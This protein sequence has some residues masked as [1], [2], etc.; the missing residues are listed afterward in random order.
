MGLI[1]TIVLKTT[2]D[3]NLR[4][5]YC[6]EFKRDEYEDLN[7][8]S[9]SIEFL[10]G[11]IE[12]FAILFPDSEILWMLHGGEPLLKGKKFFDEF[13]SKLVEV[14][15]KYNVLFNVALQTNGSLIDDEWIELFSK[16]QDIFSERIISISIDGDKIVNDKAR[17]T[18]NNK[19]SFDNVFNAINLLKKTDIKITTITVVGNHNL[20]YANEIY[21]F[22]RSIQPHFVKFIPCYNFN[23]YGEVEKDGIRPLEYSKFMIDIFDLWI[24]DIG[25]NKDLYKKFVIDP[26]ASII[27]SITGT[28]VTWCEY[29]EEKCNNFLT[30]FPN[31][32][33]WFC[34]S[35]EHDIQR[36][37][38]YICN[39]ENVTDDELKDFISSKKY[40]QYENFYNQIHT[41]C[42]KCDINNICHGGCIAYRDIFLKK[43]ENLF[44]EYCAAKHQLICYMKR[45]VDYALPK[46]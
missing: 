36:D 39:L 27:A 22:L 18:K 29:R 42:S 10:C 45:V 9:M 16:Y 35:F 24:K 6:Y 26:I 5:S 30:L 3:C 43:S 17:L 38:A 44:S 23:N 46:Y 15:S 25:K 41:A 20:K 12:K 8:T 2:L 7:L 37:K 28:L 32:E 13:C 40:P 19:S 11:L 31:K 21:T 33:L 1:K 34:D 14:N 4:C